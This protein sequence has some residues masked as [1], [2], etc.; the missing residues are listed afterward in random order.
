MTRC[1]P[2]RDARW[3]ARVGRKSNRL[4]LSVFPCGCAWADRATNPITEC[5]RHPRKGKLY[6]VLDAQ[7]R[8]VS[9]HTT[10]AAAKAAKKRL[11]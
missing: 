10:L 6:E 5:P 9:T 1:S 8:V 4:R 7:G 11:G 2:R 3:Y